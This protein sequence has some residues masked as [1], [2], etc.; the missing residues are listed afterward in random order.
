M[1][2]PRLGNIDISGSIRPLRMSHT[3]NFI[4]KGKKLTFLYLNRLLSPNIDLVLTILIYYFSRCYKND[5][6]S[7]ELKI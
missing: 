7:P 6:C 3:S 1:L 4:R 5:C 2:Q